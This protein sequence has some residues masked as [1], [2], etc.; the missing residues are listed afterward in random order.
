M[1][2]LHDLQVVKGSDDIPIHHNRDALE[3]APRSPKKPRMPGER[4]GE[5][6][7]GLLN[8]AKKRNHMDF[9]VGAL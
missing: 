6:W 1:V 5:T 4:G 2:V 3:N 8:P 9:W 7:P